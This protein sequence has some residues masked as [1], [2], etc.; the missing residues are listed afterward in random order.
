MK[1]R[2]FLAAGAA[3]VPAGLT[4][5][6]LRPPAARQGPR[7]NLLLIMTDQQPA[8]LMSCTGNR[9][10]YTPAMDSLAATGVRFEQTYCT[11]PICV[12]SRTTMMTGRMSHET[13]VMVN[14]DRFTVPFESMGKRIGQAGYDTAYIGKWHI[15]MESGNT[16]WTGF[17]LM[18]EGTRE[19]ND[20][21]FAEPAIRFLRQK[22]ENP[23]FLVTSFVNPHDICEYARKLSGGFPEQSTRLWN[24]P[25]PEAPPPEQC[26]PLPD[27]FEIP[28]SEPEI[29]RE[30]QSWMPGTYPS[31]DWTS[32]QWRQYRWAL[33]RLTERVDSEIAKLLD[34]LRSEGLDQN[35]IVLL[36]SDHGDGNGAHQWNQKTL[37]YEE[38]ARVPLILSGPG[39][40][41]P[42][43]T[44]HDHLVSAGLDL[45]PTLCDYAEIDPPDGLRG[46]S[47]R[48]LA[49]GRPAEWRDAV[50]AECVLHRQYGLG[51]GIEGRMLRTRRYKYIVYS[52]GKRRE[53]LFDMQTD[54]GEMNNLAERPDFQEV[55]ASHRLRLAEQ[56]RQS[57]DYFV[58][59]GIPYDGWKL[60]L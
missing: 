30:H 49:E 59:P 29:I 45:F 32:G 31:R 24:G 5:T 21:H 22:R 57:G 20:Q 37:L 58:V 44:D 27:N 28:D 38:P 23:F 6:S 11:N 8:E 9:H 33:N 18:L 53:Q 1:R 39:M 46:L 34:A 17:D 15:P 16:A 10:L 47:L 48:P 36:V 4:A 40:A 14:M 25:I 13:G 51:T 2:N 41:V 60:D 7:P 55:L 54:P 56:G 3:A 42:G 52:A 43:R 35:T 19:F 50:T 12:P 26:P